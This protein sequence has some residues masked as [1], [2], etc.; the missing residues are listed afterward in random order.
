MS[1]TYTPSTV[2][3]V[4]VGKPSAT[5]TTVVIVTQTL[6]MPTI[7]ETPLSDIKREGHCGLDV[8]SGDLHDIQKDLNCLL[9]YR[10]KGWDRFTCGEM[11]FW[12]RGELWKDPKDCY[13]G[14]VACLALDIWNG[15][16]TQT[17]CSYKKGWAFCSMGYNPA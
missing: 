12:R 16:R 7:N 17:A 6:T 11:T 3:T 14:C 9:E 2:T 10:D 5:T 4:V 13:D 8:I 1:D 15:K